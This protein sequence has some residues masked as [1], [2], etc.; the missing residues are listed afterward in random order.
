MYE[1]TEIKYDSIIYMNIKACITV[2]SLEHGKAEYY[3]DDNQYITAPSLEQY[4]KATYK[5]IHQEDSDSDS[6]DNEDLRAIVRAAPQKLEEA[7]TK[8]KETLVHCRQLRNLGQFIMHFG[9]RK[10]NDIFTSQIKLLPEFESLKEKYFLAYST[11]IAAILP[12]T[13]TEI[14]SL[15]LFSVLKAL[16][17][18]NVIPSRILHTLCEVLLN[19]PDYTMPLPLL[20]ILLPHLKKALNDSE[21]A[22][23]DVIPPPTPL[24]LPGAPVTPSH[25]IQGGAGGE[26][27]GFEGLGLPVPSAPPA[28]A[29]DVVYPLLDPTIAAYG[30]PADDIINVAWPDTLNFPVIVVGGASGEATGFEGLERQEPN[31]AAIT[32]PSTAMALSAVTL[33]TQ[34]QN[35]V[36]LITTSLKSGVA[37]TEVVS[38]SET[39]FRQQ[40]LFALANFLRTESNVKHA[41]QSDELR[42]HFTAFLK[43]FPKTTLKQ[44]QDFARALLTRSQRWSFGTSSDYRDYLYAL[45]T[46]LNLIVDSVP[47]A[48]SVRV[49][50]K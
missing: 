10:E 19:E 40:A 24:T 22:A 41:S 36:R 34:Y 14:I 8:E 50:G 33:G 17:E 6:E 2:S 15:T 1:I 48:V 29:I 35:A 4:E 16:N 7:I 9:W 49:V 30:P 43:S 47:E 46:T 32:T 12:F 42:P 23:G 3:V 21:S 31:G 27:T 25:I 37:I 20:Q 44:I 26:A 45:S 28:D 39:D 13:K 11:G 5:A 38:S 18:R